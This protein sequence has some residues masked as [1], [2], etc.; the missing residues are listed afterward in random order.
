MTPDRFAGHTDW[1]DTDHPLVRE[2][3]HW[4]AR[5]AHTVRDA[6]AAVFLWVRDSIAYTMGDW[7]QRA[8]E[9]I[10]RGAGTSANKANLV[11][12]LARALGIPAGFCVRH[13]TTS[14]YFG[15]AFIPVVAGLMR[16]VAI[17]VSPVLV[18]EGRWVHCDPTHDR[19]LG[20]A[21]GA[22]VPHARVLAFDGISEAAI[23]FPAG[24]IRSER[25]ALTDIDALLS[26]ACRTS[27]ATQRLL[28][29]YI[30]FLRDRGASY[31]VDSNAERLEADFVR[32]LLAVDPRGHA[33]L[34]APPVA[35][36]A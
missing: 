12:A 9:T 32:H 28:A 25:A 24:S 16:D 36:A 26:T 21:I 1:C 6:A 29:C 2:L 20:N 31:S 30:A 4:I 34:V 23:P 13:V 17:H 18:I 3:A 35:H 7:N 8:S 22:L 11:V 33:E 14:V 19:P 27:P 5:D 10:V 15:G